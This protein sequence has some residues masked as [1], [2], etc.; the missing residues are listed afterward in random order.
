MNNCQQKR[1]KALKR[2]TGSRKSKAMNDSSRAEI[3]DITEAHTRA[4]EEVR[5]KQEAEIANLKGRHQTALAEM[6]K[7]HDA[8]G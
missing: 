1:R 6:E 2:K 4:V 5:S 8:V 7:E 3:T